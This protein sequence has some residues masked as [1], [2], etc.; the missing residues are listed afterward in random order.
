MNSNQLTQMLPIRFTNIEWISGYTFTAFDS[1]EKKYCCIKRLKLTTTMHRDFYFYQVM[2]YKL[3][4]HHG[5]T[6]TF[7]FSIATEMYGY[8]ATELWHR[9]LKNEDMLPAMLLSELKSKLN[10]MHDLGYLH[11]DL[12]HKNIVV[13]VW[14]GEIEDVALIDFEMTITIMKARQVIIPYVLPSSLISKYDDEP[15]LLD[16]EILENMF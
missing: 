12:H 8:I 9:T 10:R 11:N 5:V 4:S 7:L 6:P 13:K 14:N 2:L 15:E 16:R 1:I 3:F